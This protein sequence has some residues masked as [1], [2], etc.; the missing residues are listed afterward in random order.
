MRN[1]I[2]PIIG[3]PTPDKLIIAVDF[4][5]TICQHPGERFPE[6]GDPVPHCLEVLHR[7]REAGHRLM[8]WTLRDGEHLNAAAK[9]LLDNGLC[10]WGWNE[11]PDQSWSTSPKQY[12][13]L[14]ID[15]KNV[16][17]PLVHFSDGRA[18]VDWYAI[19]QYLIEM[20]VLADPLTEVDAFITMQRMMALENTVG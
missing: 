8:L 10:C 19:E 17:C 14:T 15:D 18:Y 3:G 2:E 20:G 11:N 4:D 6:I 12:A 1:L 9:Y 13:H 5:G 7:L 16:G